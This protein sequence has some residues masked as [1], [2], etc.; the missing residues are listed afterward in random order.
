MKKHPNLTCFGYRIDCE[1][2]HDSDG[3]CITWKGTCL[4]DHKTVVIKQFCFGVASSSWL[5]Y[6]AYEQE[7]RILKNIKHPRIPSY[8]DSI[9]TENGF[10]LIQEHINASNLCHFPPLTLSE[11]KQ[12]SLQLLDILVFL[13]DRNNPI[14]HRDINPENILL[15]ENLNAYLVDFSVA[16]FYGQELSTNNIFQKTSSFIV[17][18]QNTEPTLS[19]DLY[20]LGVT[21]IYLLA[22]KD[23]SIVCKFSMADNSNQ[24]E[25]KQLL[26]SLEQTFLD[27]LNTMIQPQISKRFADAITARNE[28]LFFDPEIE[29]SQ[30]R[31]NYPQLDVQLTMPKIL[32]AIG[33][34]IVSAITTWS[35]DFVQHQISLTSRSIAIAMIAVVAIN[36]AQLGAISI[37]KLDQQARFVS[38]AISTITPAILVFVGGLIWGIEEAVTIVM[39]I[40]LAEV[41]ILSVFWWKIPDW[42]AQDFLIKLG[43]LVSA[44]S[45]GIGVGLQLI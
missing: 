39:A 12:I 24:L 37:A 16:S 13:Q 11:I 4:N 5:G 44:I 18:E 31:N 23:I 29:L 19:S 9:E 7:I 40:T 25:L 32:G 26:P 1:L 22:N 28:L 34:M 36:V 15:D 41:F 30:L 21:I 6:E 14:L 43:S 17:P 33:I 3:D 35:I 45:L 8:L 38:L 10:C 42:T 27:W 2:G 20:S